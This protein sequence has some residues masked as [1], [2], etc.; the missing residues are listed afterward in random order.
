MQP[1]VILHINY[2]NS[3]A[4]I[5]DTNHDLTKTS[6]EMKMVVY[7]LLDES[8]L[9]VIFHTLIDKS[10]MDQK[11]SENAGHTSLYQSNI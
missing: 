9:T 5:I 8:N 1:T 4:F 7:R 10:V 3:T 6:T 11:V 2:F